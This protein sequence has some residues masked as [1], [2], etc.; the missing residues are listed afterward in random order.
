M[1]QSRSACPESRTIGLDSNGARP[2]RRAAAAFAVLAATQVTLIATITVVTVALPDIQRDLRLDSASLVLLGSAYGVS[3]GG[4]LPL[5]GRLADVW[6]RRRAFVGGT[7]VFALASAAAGF[8]PDYGVLLGARFIQGIGAASTA[9]AAIALLGTIFPDAERRR[10]ATAVW[11]VLSGAGATAGTVM[12]GFFITW[13]A[14][15]W[16]FLAPVLVSATAAVAVLRLIPAPTPAA[17]TR[18][19]TAATPPIDWPGAALVTA[20]LAALVYGVQHSGWMFLGG[21]VLLIAFAIVER[22]SPAPLLPLPLLRRRI[23]PL[24]AIALCAGTMATAYFL[25]SLYLQQVRDFSPAQTSAVFLL[26]APAILV[27]GP[28]AGRLAARLSPRRVLA[29]GLAVA[30]AGLLLISLLSFPYLGLAVFP[31]GAGLTFSAAMLAVMETTPD[32][33]AA[34]AGGALNAAMEVGPSLG[35]AAFVALADTRSPDPAVGYSFVL[36]IAAA[37]VALIALLALSTRENS[38]RDGIST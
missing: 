16:L 7:A 13:L 21:A 35:L 27:S 31:L 38:E 4:L 34:L 1:T 25:V 29:L 32:G 23:M 9:P 18:D 36:R 30:A 2:S 37:A 5:G 17:T 20:G 22:R 26:P 28:L 10:R 11:G 14:W 8:T 24:T 3:F 6:G 12:S 15:R 19:A 33:Q